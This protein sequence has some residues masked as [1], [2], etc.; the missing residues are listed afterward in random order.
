MSVAAITSTTPS[1]SSVPVVQPTSRREQADALGRQLVQAIQSGDLA[2]A[3]KAYAALSAFGPNNSGPFK[4]QLAADFEAVGQALQSGDLA[5]AKQAVTALGNRLLSND[6]KAVQQQ[7][8][9]G[10]VQSAQ[11]VIANLEGDR[12]ALT[13]QGSGPVA[14][15]PSVPTT[16][17]GGTDS[18]ATVDLRA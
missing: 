8:Q 18:A 12:W 16:T 1:Q 15:V 14:S 7:I 9:E 4:H 6:L 5:G 11:H 10:G 3:Q 2:G 17:G 13:G